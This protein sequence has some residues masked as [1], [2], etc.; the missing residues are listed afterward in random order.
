MWRS[1]IFHSKAPGKKVPAGQF[2]AVVAANRLRQAALTDHLIQHAG[3]AST[4][5]AGVHFQRQALA[6]E[7]IDH[8]QHP[9]RASSRD[10]IMSEVQR[11]LL[12][13]RSQ[14]HTRRTNAGAVFTLLPLQT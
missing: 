1:S 5:E 12:V 2:R 6:G 10:H 8:A 13:G 11:P 7:G 9:D 3:H 14:L 4:G